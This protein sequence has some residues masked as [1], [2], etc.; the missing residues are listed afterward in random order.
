MKVFV[1][2]STGLLGNNLVRELLQQGHEVKALVRSLAKAKQQFGDLPIGYVQGDMDDISGFE[3]ELAG[4]QALFHTAAYF[5]EYFGNGDHWQTLEKINVTGTIELFRAAMRQGVE[6]I[7]HTSSSGVIDS[8]VGDESSGPN[9][10]ADRNLYFKSKVVSDQKIRELVATEGA[11]VIT[12]LPGWMLGPGD[13]APTASGQM[14]LDF[15]EGKLPG[16]FD[17]GASTVDAR[18]VAL[19]MISAVSKGKVGERYI[20]GGDYVPMKT[21]IDALVQVSGI[22]GAQRHIPTGLLLIFAGLS[23]LYGRVTG[24]D[25]LITREGVQ[26]MLDKQKVSSAKAMR[27]LGV[28]FRPL[29]ETLSDELAF[30]AAAGKIPARIKLKPSLRVTVGVR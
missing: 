6:R 30:Y 9:P 5:R 16:W 3:A 19:A 21:L 23:E 18:D 24:K 8:A 11:P 2:G 15:V 29:T 4:C 13:L 1:T 28:K 27:E 17:G 20:V 10:H 25:V 26:T 12:I 14:V 7:I 22:R